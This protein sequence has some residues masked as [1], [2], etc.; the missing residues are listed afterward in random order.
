MK[1]A[2]YAKLKDESFGIRGQN[3]VQGEEVEITTKAGKVVIETVG[4][5][6][7]T[8]EDGNCLARKASDTT[9]GPRKGAGPL[10]T[11]SAGA[12]CR[13]CG[14]KDIGT[15]PATQ[16]QGPSRR[17]WGGTDRTSHAPDNAP[18]NSDDVPF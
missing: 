5:V 9:E 2:S 6:L 1:T 7:A 16:T 10:R 11:S 3:L 13:S 18:D 17:S 12:F 4:H 8:F 14:G 15:A